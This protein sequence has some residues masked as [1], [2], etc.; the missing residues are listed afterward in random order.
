MS[1]ESLH[2][3]LCAGTV[4][5]AAGQGVGRDG[6]QELPPLHFRS[7]SDAEDVV[8]G[9]VQLGAVDL[10]TQLEMM[11]VM[12]TTMMIMITMT[13]TAVMMHYLWLFPVLDF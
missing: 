1:D 3:E 6:G 5:E 13:V 4:G 2:A 9:Q 11:M 10:S 7:V 12:V 8:N